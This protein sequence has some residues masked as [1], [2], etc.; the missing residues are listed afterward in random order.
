M[1]KIK[2]M[3]AFLLA[4]AMML[5]MSTAAFADNSYSITITNPS[6]SNITI[7]D[8]KFDAY[9][10]FD[11]AYADTDNETEGNEVYAY[12]ITRNSA[13]FDSVVNYAYN[14]ATNDGNENVVTFNGKSYVAKADAA[15]TLTEAP[16]KPGTYVVGTNFKSESDA[17]AFAD[18]LFESKGENISADGTVTAPEGTEQ[19]PV[20]KDSNGNETITI[21]VNTP[22]YY[23]VTGSGTDSS[24]Q[25]VV[26]AAAL[27]TT[28]P[29]ANIELKA[30]APPL[31]KSIVD[32]DDKVNNNGTAVNVGDTVK[33]QLTSK[34]PDTTGY[35]SYTFLITD[36]LSSGLTLKEESAEATTFAVTIGTQSVS[37][38][39]AASADNMSGNVYY[40]TKNDNETTTVKISLAM[41]D[42]N[43]A[44]LYK[45][46]DTIKVTYSATLNKKA[47][48]TDE[49]NNTATL[50]YSNNPYENT[51]ATTTETKVYVYDFSIDVYKYAAG[52]NEKAYLSGA[53]F[54]LYR[55]ENG[56]NL[57]Y[58]YTSDS[59]T[60]PAAVTW[61]GDINEAT[62][63]I[64]TSE[65]NIKFEGLDSGTYYLL[66]TEA[67]TGYNLLT[68]PVKV[69]I[70]VT[71]DV[72]GQIESV[73]YTI[74]NE[75][76]PVKLDGT[77]ITFSKEVEVANTAGSLLPSTGGMGT[78]VLYIV[79]AILV[80]GAGVLLIVKRRMNAE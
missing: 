1:K 30:S 65:G 54:V 5:A 21:T 10:I 2:K 11:V 50:T 4:A 12:T 62:S 42:A 79:G 55:V 19:N 70:T 75:S 51:S 49:E 36:T 78:T 27:T 6:G 47:L 52:D 74:D 37:L 76:D 67:P 38:T 8:K 15:L 22:G 73:T 34:V 56:T 45:E 63:K 28:D 32:A 41:L 46:G 26:A 25:S 39:K 33:F 68:A 69:D 9:K 53:T 80:I 35:E 77:N 31:D 23:L 60:A 3:L 7:A 17:R 14:P 66:E 61:V 64:T 20:L 16:G 44:A 59:E 58:K 43:S 48:M 18:Y 72:D 29:A 40:I 24:N 57:Y 13:W 71:Y